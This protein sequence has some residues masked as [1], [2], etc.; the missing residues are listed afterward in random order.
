M[1]QTERTTIRIASENTSEIKHLLVD[2][3]IRF[4][5]RSDLR[6]NV[7]S[8]IVLQCRKIL[9]KHVLLTM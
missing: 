7:V 8:S 3:Y 9:Y 2:H 1:K 4:P 5:R 6:I